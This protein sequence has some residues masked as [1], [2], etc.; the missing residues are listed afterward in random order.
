MWLFSDL[1]MIHYIFSNQ[2]VDRFLFPILKDLTVSAGGESTEVPRRTINPVFSQQ[3][4]EFLYKTSNSFF[5]HERTSNKIIYNR[6]ELIIVCGTGI[7][8][9]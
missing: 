6:N 4:I 1:Q 7:E 3:S 2:N 8:P 5:N 9:H